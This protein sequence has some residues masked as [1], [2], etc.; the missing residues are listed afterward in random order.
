M[1]LSKNLFLKIFLSTAVIFILNF[2]TA[3][4][5]GEDLGGIRS[6]EV[7]SSSID[8]IGDMD[9]FNF[10]GKAGEGIMIVM[11]ETSGAT[12]FFEYL[13]LYD[14][15]G[16]EETRGFSPIFNHQLKKTGLYTIVCRTVWNDVAG[17]YNLSFLKIPGA[18]LS[19]SDKD[20]G[21]IVSGKVY[22][23]QIT[24]ISDTDAVNF[25]GAAGE[26]VLIT[27]ACGPW[28]FIEY[29]ELYDPDG[30]KETAGYSPISNYQLKKTG[31]YTIVCRD[32][33]NNVAGT[34]NL[35]FTKIPPALPPGVYNPSPGNGAIVSPLTNLV[36]WSDTPGATYYDVYFG[37]DVKTPLTK[38]GDNISVSHCSLPPL[39]NKTSYYWIVVAKTGSAEI[40][41]PVWIFTTEYQKDDF[42]GT[43]DSQGV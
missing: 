33:H 18:T 23:G 20:G 5:S 22:S 43:W 41:G 1:P 31:L 9:T 34:Y 15:D 32:F 19:P 16:I 40:Q 14:P 10:Y 6:G 42:I 27:M 4:L 3:D 29:L 8:P 2:F 12:G 30:I 28:D 36:D 24:P 38:I 7:R 26:T 13:E 11:T 37:T 21:D 35:S 25:Y 17:T 39:L